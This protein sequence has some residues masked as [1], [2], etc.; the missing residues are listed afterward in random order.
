MKIGYRAPS[1]TA[2]SLALTLALAGCGGPSEKADTGAATLDESA[3]TFGTPSVGGTGKFYMGREIPE[4]EGSP[5]A[6]W[7]DR[8]SREAEEHTEKVA[9]NLDLEPDDV[10]ADIGAGTGFFTF[11]INPL[12]PDGLVYAEDIDPEMLQV[13][14]RRKANRQAANVT[15]VLGTITDPGLP[16]ESVDLVLL[17][18]TY[19]AFT[20]PKEMM[21]AITAAMKPGARLVVIEHRESTPP[22][23]RLEAIPK[24]ELVAEMEAAGLTLI[25]D[26]DV[27][28][29][30]NFLV[31]RKP[32]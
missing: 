3:Y 15:T 7:L 5:D 6:A 2:F 1:L 27:L 26:K 10:I 22:A 20:Y 24:G 21:R 9:A 25:D 31:F 30:Q 32:S 29:V 16:K 11:R 18:E 14:E 8:T 28:P 19:H 12:V 17:V 4:I 13:I 23:N